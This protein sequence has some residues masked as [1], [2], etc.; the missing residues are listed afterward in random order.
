VPWFDL[1]VAGS[2]NLSLSYRV[3]YGTQIPP[4]FVQKCLVNESGSLIFFE[5]LGE[6]TSLGIGE[7]IN[8]GLIRTAINPSLP[9]FTPLHLTLTFTGSLVHRS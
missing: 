6:G 4:I 7:S 2:Q 3:R 5:A 9:V 1:L 8:I